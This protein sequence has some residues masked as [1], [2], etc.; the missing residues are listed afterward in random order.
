MRIESVPSSAGWIALP[1]AVGPRL[2]SLYCYPRQQA[3]D[4]RRM[5]R[6]ELQAVAHMCHVGLFQLDVTRHT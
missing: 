1:I 3:N 5:T 4:K 6:Q 2:T